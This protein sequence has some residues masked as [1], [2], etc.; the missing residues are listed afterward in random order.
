V[1]QP[2]SKAEG[3]LKERRLREGAEELW[4]EFWKLGQKSSS[5]PDVRVSATLTQPF[6]GS[7]QFTVETGSGHPFQLGDDQRSGLRPIE[8][9]GAALAGCTALSVLAILRHEKNQE[10]TGYEVRVEADQG[11]RPPH[12]LVAVRIH[13]VISGHR[14][15]PAAVNDAIRLSEKFC[16]IQSMMRHSAVI[17]TTFELIDA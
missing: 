15:D 6:S 17:T 5:G 8:L 16:A 10:I 3:F 14:I 9:L 4:H 1:T 13:H 2:G 11:E 12:A 7:H